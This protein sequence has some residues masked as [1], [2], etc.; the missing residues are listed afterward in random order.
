MELGVES[1]QRNPQKNKITGIVTYT[2]NLS[3][4][5]ESEAWKLQLQASQGK[6]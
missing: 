3:S 4:S 5:R 2:Y 6:C 1:I